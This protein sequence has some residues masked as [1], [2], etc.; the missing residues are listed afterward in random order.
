[1]SISREGF[2]YVRKLVH[3]QSGVVLDAGKEYL[4]EARLQ[5]L[6]ETEGLPS[7]Q[8]LI[9]RL[10]ASSVTGLLRRVVDAMTTNETFFFRDLQ[11]FEQLRRVVFPQVIEKRRAER[12]I[13][14]WSG[15]CSTGQEP[16]SIAMII[17]EHFPE[18]LGWSCQLMASDI[19]ADI[20]ARACLGRY[21]QLEVSRGLPA[22]YLVKYFQKHG[23]EWQLN[24]DLRRKV[25]FFEIN[26]TKPW[27]ALPRMDIIMMRNVLIYFDLETKKQIFAN[28]KH[29]LHS[30]GW[31][32]L[33]GSE[34]TLGIDESFER[35]S[36][37]ASGWFRPR[38]L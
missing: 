29:Q 38:K 21:S 25:E 30:E 22:H 36:G 15:A 33:G 26:L 12:R 11:P 6:A 19:A 18:L 24:E 14:I 10:R 31:L 37:D 1:M 34:T 32:S 7:V 35:V 2:D 3:S 27:P 23:A 9:E 8:T 13:T 17:K 5:P 28:L 16:Y 4:V 20:M